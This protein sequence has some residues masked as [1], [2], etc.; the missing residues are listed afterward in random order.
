MHSTYE[1]SAGHAVLMSRQLIKTALRLFGKRQEAQEGRWEQRQEE[2]WEFDYKQVQKINFAEIFSLRLSNYT[3]SNSTLTVD[4]EVLQESLN[5]AFDKARKWCP[6]AYAVGRVY[7]M[8]YVIG[9][10]VYLD[11]IPQS[12]EISTNIVGDEVHG[13]VA[14]S[15]IKKVGQHTYA[16]LTSYQFDQ[17]A[18]TFTIENKAV[19]WDNGAEVGLATVAEWATVE[20]QTILRGIDKP[21][22]G[23]VDCPKDNRDTDRMQGAPI[24]YGCEQT[25][26]EIH[27]CIKQYQIE[28]E[29]KVSILG[30]DREAI[31]S[32]NGNTSLPK[33][34]IRK[35][36]TGR[37]SDASDLFSVYS[38]EIRS[39]AYQQRLL[40]LFAR[41]EKQVGVSTGIL[42]PA[43]T[44]M[45]TATQ[46]RRAMYDTKA[47]VDRMRA[48]IAQAFDALA[49][50]YT[51]MLDLIGYRVKGE[52][53]LT[54]DWSQE[55]TEDTQETFAQLT[56]GY[57]LGVVSDVE[58]RQF[59][60]PDESPQ[61]AERVIAEIQSKKP[62]PL[63]S[64]FPAEP[65]GDVEQQEERQPVTEGGGEA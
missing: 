45:A 20:P 23:V 5:R 28:Y 55:M 61:D 14:V 11:I 17:T 35:V 59:I 50:G 25:I 37:L 43:T 27:E 19:R 30:I 6:M 12:K 40:D 24:T 1:I 26:N 8:P 29:H 36:N 31:D 54:F 21:I 51:V 44:S 2:R 13:F 47:M 65:F 4:D 7:L 39:N 64:M 63:A 56:Q 22:F 53:V 60:Y 32:T 9:D 15:D 46:V 38:P 18:K 52:P 34:F 58:L 3:I 62:D 57:S 33:E 41:L 10:K 16:R 49:Y 42:T 48:N